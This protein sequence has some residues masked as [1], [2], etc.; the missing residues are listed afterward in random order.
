MKDC[1]LCGLDYQCCFHN[2][3]DFMRLIRDLGDRCPARK[4][5]YN[6]CTCFKD[7]KEVRR[8]RYQKILNSL[9]REVKIR[10]PQSSDLS[11]IY[12]NFI[13]KNPSFK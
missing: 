7:K 9:P 4:D 3:S 10:M 5:S 1:Y 2:K 12:R 13:A 11:D 8:R 6:H